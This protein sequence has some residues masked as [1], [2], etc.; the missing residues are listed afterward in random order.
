VALAGTAI[1]SGQAAHCTTPHALVTDLGWAYREGRL[2]WNLR[3]YVAP[4]LRIM[5]SPAQHRLDV[6]ASLGTDQYGKLIL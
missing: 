5:V 3:I 2:D 6:N 1:Q 4:K